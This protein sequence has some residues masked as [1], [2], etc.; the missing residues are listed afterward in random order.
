[1]IT[2]SLGRLARKLEPVIVVL[3]LLIYVNPNVPPSVKSVMKYSGYGLIALLV[4][5][6]GI[7]RWRQFAYVATRDIFPWLLL[8]LSVASVLW[9]AAPQY[10]SDEVDPVI[11]SVIFGVYLAMRYTPKRQIQL[12]TWVLGIVAVLSLM[13]PIVIPPYG[14]N[15]GGRWY[16]IF[17]LHNFLARYMVIGVITFLNIALDE[18]RYRWLTLIGTGLAI[19]LV[20]LSQSKSSLIILILSLSLLP[21][22]KFIK[23]D[24]KLR[25]VLFIFSFL[26]VSSAAVLIFSNL[27]TIV[28]DILGKNMQFNGRLPLWNLIVEKGLER[29]WLGYGYA[30]FWTSDAGSFVQSL[31]PWGTRTG[32]FYAHNGLVEMFSQLGFVGLSLCLLS[33]V[34]LM[35]RTVYLINSTRSREFFWL[36]QFLIVFFLSNLSELGFLANDTLWVLYVSMSF[37]TGVWCKRIKRKRNA[38]TYNQKLLV[39]KELIK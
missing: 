33:F 29:P 26:L 17:V 30:G 4:F 32:R 12:I 11:R 24:Y 20:L 39:N 37:S 16:G 2:E 34:M 27:E 23:Q 36:F 28:V 3:L 5:G 9:S 22:Y 38:L 7:G 31:T 25:V 19:A 21:L 18:R 13:L 8:G 6:A 10:T 35:L 15:A 1:M 14:I